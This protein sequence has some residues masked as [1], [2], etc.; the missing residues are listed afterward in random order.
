MISDRD[1]II[2]KL[3]QSHWGGD[4]ELKKMEGGMVVILI[5]FP[6]KNSYS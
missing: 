2:K 1:K 5:F 6:F 4:F 3:L